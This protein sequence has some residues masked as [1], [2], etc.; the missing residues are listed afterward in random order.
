MGSCY[1][2]KAERF[3]TAENKWEA[4]ANIMQE[5]RGCASGV[6][7]EGKNFF[8]KIKS[9]ISWGTTLCENMTVRCTIFLLT[10]GS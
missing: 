6:A 2:A 10:N 5:K 9:G 3:D 4:I 1:V 7:T 8:R